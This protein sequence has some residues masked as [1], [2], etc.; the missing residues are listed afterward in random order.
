MTRRFALSA[1]L[2]LGAAMLSGCANEPGAA[3]GTEAE[4][5]R[6][7]PVPGGFVVHLNSEVTSEVAV[8]SH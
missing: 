6:A 5:Q 3:A 7:A 4:S 1:T 2:L 8:S